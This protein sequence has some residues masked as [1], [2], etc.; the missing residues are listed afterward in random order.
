[1]SV[2]DVFAIHLANFC[3]KKCDRSKRT[4]TSTRASRSRFTILLSSHIKMAAFLV[5]TPIVAKTAAKPAVARR[6]TT[7][8]AAASSE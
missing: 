2:T 1:M 8:K 4:I 3:K 6:N 7:V 5:G